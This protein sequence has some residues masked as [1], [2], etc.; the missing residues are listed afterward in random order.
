VW[1]H[2]RVGGVPRERL[3]VPETV[4]ESFMLTPEDTT[5]SVRATF[6]AACERSR[7]VAADHALDEQFPWHHGPVSLRFIYAHMIEELARHAGHGDILVEQLAAGAS[8]A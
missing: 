2:S 1:F 7:E 8:G 5:G 4:D 3:G 6:L